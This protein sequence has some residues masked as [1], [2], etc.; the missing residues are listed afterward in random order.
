MIETGV[1]LLFCVGAATAQTVVAL[2][3]LHNKERKL[4]DCYWWDGPRPGGFSEVGKLLQRLGAEVR[5]L[6][7]RVTPSTLSGLAH[8]VQDEV[9]ALG[10]PWLYNE[11]IDRK[12][13]SRVATNLFRMLLKK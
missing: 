8:A 6:K 4:P 1:L 9:F 7:E 12:D 5:T 3:G 10:D 2:D 11:Y 13:Y